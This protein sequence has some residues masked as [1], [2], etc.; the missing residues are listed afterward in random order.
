MISLSIPSAE[1]VKEDLQNKTPLL[2]G[3]TNPPPAT[4]AVGNHLRPA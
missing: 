2:R 3:T 1:I 4:M